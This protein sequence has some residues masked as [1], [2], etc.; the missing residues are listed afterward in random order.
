MVLFVPS[1]NLTKVLSLSRLLKNL[2]SS[3]FVF[4]VS[5]LI[6]VPVLAVFPLNV[7]EEISVLFPLNQIA[8]PSLGVWALLSVKV[9]FVIII[10]D[11]SIFAAPPFPVALFFL[12]IL[13]FN[14]DLS[15]T[16]FNAP[17]VPVA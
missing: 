12:N 15:P 17:P 5:P 11:P 9:L 2:L 16:N 6:A 14:V 1:A 8:P 10:L 7:F 4:D 13:L 3:T